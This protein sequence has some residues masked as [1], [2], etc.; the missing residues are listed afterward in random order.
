MFKKKCLIDNIYIHQQIIKKSLQNKN[1]QFIEN[2][3]YV[4]Q[5]INYFLAENA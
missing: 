5:H 1:E 3:I 2:Y 4:K